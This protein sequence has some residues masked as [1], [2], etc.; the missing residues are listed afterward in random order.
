MSEEKPD[1]FTD[2]E[3]AAF[4][5][6]HPDLEEDKVVRLDETKRKRK[7]QQQPPL[8]GWPPWFGELRRDDRGRVYPDLRN[9]LIAVRR[10]PRT[11]D[12]FHFDEM[13]RDPIIVEPPPIAPGAKDGPPP[14][15]P[16]ADDDVSRLQEWLQHVGLPRIARETVRQAIE[17]I[18][19]EHRFHPIRDWLDSL[20]WDK[21]ERLPFWLHDCLETPNDEYHRR[22]RTCHESER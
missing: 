5:R 22:R 11:M 20:A 13:A 21:K 6:D 14:P 9:V 15:R 2:E 16:L 10:E 17:T 7:K 18:A 1:Y 4:L 3:W 8:G 19:R 12:A